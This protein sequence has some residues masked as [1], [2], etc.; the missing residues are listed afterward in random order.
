MF[1]S[2]PRVV[3][4]K[5][6][7][8]KLVEAEQGLVEHIAQETARLTQAGLPVDLQP[9]EDALKELHRIRKK[10]ENDL[11]ELGFSEEVLDAQN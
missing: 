5:R 10:A 9:Q 8:A 1:N 11:V 2:D 6:G 4:F 3:A 7:V